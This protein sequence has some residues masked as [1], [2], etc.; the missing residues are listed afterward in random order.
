MDR[1]AGGL[2]GLGRRRGVMDA[3]GEMRGVVGIFGFW[4]TSG[5]GL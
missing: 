1:G 5:L 4:E 2:M 3:E